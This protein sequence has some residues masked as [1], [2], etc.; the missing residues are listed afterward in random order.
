MILIKWIY[1][2]IGLLLICM[3]AYQFMDGLLKYL[4]EPTFMWTQIMEQSEQ[5]KHNFPILIVC[6]IHGYKTQKLMDK[7]GISNYTH[8][9][10]SSNQTIKPQSIFNDVTFRVS[11]LI[12]NII[13]TQLIN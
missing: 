6:P 1:F 5:S 8:Q 3:A 4:G 10:I 9:W 11:T 2:L 12:L 13:I 7:Y